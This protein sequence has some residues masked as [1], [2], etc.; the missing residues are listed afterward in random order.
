MNKIVHVKTIEI[1]TLEG[2]DK[3]PGA[4]RVS[5][6]SLFSAHLSLLVLPSIA[7]Y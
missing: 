3:L 5:G 1:I 6:L 4:C 7:F 2:E